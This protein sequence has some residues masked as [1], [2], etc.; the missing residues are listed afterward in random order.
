M[1]FLLLT[2]S[3]TYPLRVCLGIWGP[4]SF[5]QLPTLSLGSDHFVSVILAF[6]CS[7]YIL[8]LHLCAKSDLPDG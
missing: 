2:A 5:S 4:L 6:L 1:L 8:L 7:S 3:Q